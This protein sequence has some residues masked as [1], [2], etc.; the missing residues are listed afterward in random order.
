MAVPQRNV[1]HRVLLLLP[2][3]LLAGGM[4]VML[5]AH[6]NTVRSGVMS[7]RAVLVNAVLLG[8]WLLL[9]FVLL[10]RLVRNDASRSGIL[11]ALAVAA[12]VVLV[13]PTLRDTTVNEKFPEVAVIQDRAEPTPTDGA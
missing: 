5:V 9:S 8:G 6:P 1:R 10:P 11:T 7:T 2:Q 3:L 13:V 4:L 12:I